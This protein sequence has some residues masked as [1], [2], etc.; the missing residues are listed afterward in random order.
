VAQRY[1][2]LGEEISQIMTKRVRSFA[3]SDRLRQTMTSAIEKGLK[4]TEQTLRPDDADGW[5][6]LGE[7]WFRLTGRG[8]KQGEYV[9]KTLR[10]DPEH[11]AATRLASRLDLKKFEGKW[12]TSDEYDA[13]K[14]LREAGD[15]TDR[16][17]LQEKLRELEKQR[18]AQAAARRESLLN[19]EAAL[20]DND[21]EKRS[22]TL[23]SLGSA[24]Q[25]A[26]DPVFAQRLIDILTNDRD[27]AVLASLDAAR[28]SALPA[29]R[30]QV[31][32]ALAWRSGAGI[33]PEAALA[34]LSEAIATEKDASAAKSGAGAL[35]EMGSKAAWGALIAA[36]RNAD[37]DVRSEIISGLQRATKQTFTTKEEWETWWASNKQ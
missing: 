7:Q 8:G 34:R 14:K 18:E 22:E 30:L 28:K 3:Q 9:L 23:V 36:L 10:I 25:A 19:F 35:V 1:Y 31:M 4:L 13:L 17:N 12:Y 32:E 11:A 29:V 21:P 6:S 26:A 15:E 5:F 20:R 37:S 2:Q 27:D 16:A 33:Q 24:I